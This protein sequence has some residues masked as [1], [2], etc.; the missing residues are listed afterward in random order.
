M[1]PWL[2]LLTVSRNICTP[3][4]LLAARKPRESHPEPVYPLRGILVCPLCGLPM[5]P[6]YAKTRGQIHRYYECTVNCTPMTVTKEM[7]ALAQ[8]VSDA[9]EQIQVN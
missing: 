9:L 3:A 1:K 6:T 7:C 2:N 5:K 8:R 4:E